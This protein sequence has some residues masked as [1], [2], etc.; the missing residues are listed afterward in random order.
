MTESTSDSGENYELQ[1]QYL[2]G[3]QREI[4]ARLFQSGA[5]SRVI[6]DRKTGSGAYVDVA[7]L[8]QLDSQFVPSRRKVKVGGGGEYV[9]ELSL[10]AVLPGQNSLTYSYFPVGQVDDHGILF[11]FQD[12]PKEDA[13]EINKAAQELIA[14]KEQ[15]IMPDLMF[16]LLDVYNPNTGIMKLPSEPTAKP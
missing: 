6:G 15:G 2:A 10:T 9:T 7:G 5:V 11:P 13:E 3:R 8:A 12:V 4:S 14:D 16:N 1:E